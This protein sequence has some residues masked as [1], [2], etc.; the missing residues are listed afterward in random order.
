MEEN[1]D[2]ENSLTRDFYVENEA[3]DSVSTR[4]LFRYATGFY[5]FIYYL[6]IWWSAIAGVIFSLQFVAL[7]ELLRDTRS[8]SQQRMAGNKGVLG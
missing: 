6:G 4:Q 1:T 5:G 7:R 3:K 8:R 2:I